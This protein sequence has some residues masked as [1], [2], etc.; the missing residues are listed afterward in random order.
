MGQIVGLEGWMQ[1]ALVVLAGF[2]LVVGILLPLLPVLS[3][4]LQD[5]QG[6]FVGLANYATYFANPAFAISFYNSM[7]VG[8]LTTLVSV[9]LGFAYAYALTRTA[10]RGKS[11]FQTIALAPLY[12]PSMAHAIGLI[13]LFGKKGV[14]TTGGLGYLAPLLGFN[15][16]V[17]IRL[18]GLAGIVLGEVLYCLP[19]AVLILTVAMRLTDARLYEASVAL[20]ASPVRTFFSVTLP[21]IKYG[22]VSAVF[23]CFTLAF[24]DFGVPKVVGGN[25]S[26]LATDIYKQ[27]IGQQNF[28]MG[29][30][31]S[32]LLLVPTVIA[33]VIDHLVQRRQVAMVSAR[34]VPLRPKPSRWIDTVAFM[35][36]SLIAFAIVAVLGAVL[37]AALVNVWPYRLDLTLRHFDFSSVGGGGYSAYWNSV[38]V[39]IYTAIVGTAL[40]F[41]GAYLIEKTRGL[42]WLR[43]A[44]Y[45]LSM[46]PVALPGLVIGLA[47]IFFFN[48][49]HFD[50]AGLTLPNPFAFL[51]GTG[52]ILVLANIVHFYTVSFLTATTGLKQLDRE[53][54]T[55][56]ASL[57]VPFY[58][59]FWRVTLPLCLPAVLDIGMYYFVNAMVTVSAVI[60]LY[61]PATRLAAVAIVNMDDA[62]DTAAAAAMSVLVIATSVGV[63]LLYALATRR[64]KRTTQAWNAP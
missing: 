32:T 37:L 30:T 61:A 47:Y 34:I 11:F 1:R 54:E 33:F 13:Y 16:G 6:Q 53:F 41:G 44:L 50:I 2:W 12:A 15:P 28:V 4:S 19:Q 20:R 62:G 43:S 49:K 7:L 22:L 23:V 45:F 48:P 52:A 42:R 25:F 9:G 55:V 8:I 56:S 59:T 24:T 40:T 18:Y 58:R 64:L 63:R 60:F 36:C 14:V 26:V 46:L 27:V 31:I 10:M 51:Y 57:G 21:G 38:R 39:A 17:D 35:F 29:A 5:G 3:S